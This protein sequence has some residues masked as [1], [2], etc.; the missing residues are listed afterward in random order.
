MVYLV[1]GKVGSVKTL[2]PTFGRIFEALRIDWNS[3][4]QPLS[5][6]QNEEMKF[7]CSLNGN[8]THNHFVHSH[9]ISNNYFGRFLEIVKVQLR[10]TVYTYIMMASDQ[11]VTAP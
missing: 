6:Y 8:R 5:G 4:L 11:C 9:K 10:Q 2:F 7:I 3:P 1:H